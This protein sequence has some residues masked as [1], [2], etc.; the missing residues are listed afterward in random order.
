MN[1]GKNNVT[2]NINGIVV[3]QSLTMDG[4]MSLN[5]GDNDTV[6]NNKT[7]FF[8]KVHIPFE[9]TLNFGIKNSDEITHIHSEDFFNGNHPATCKISTD[10]I[11]TN[12]KG[13]YL[14]LTFGDCIPFIVYD[15]QSEYIG[16][17]HL[18]WLSICKNLH[19]KMVHYF[20]ND[21]GA[22][23]SKLTVLLGT[24]IKSPSYNF[25][26]PAQLNMP[27]WANYINQ[28]ESQNYAIDLNAYI[29]DQLVDM[30]LPKKNIHVNPID[31]GIDKD[32]FS[33]YRSAQ[34]GEKEG[35]FIF[36]AGL[37]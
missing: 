21:I 14:Y 4:N 34:F 7:A 8:N 37:L 32:F 17:G 23:I 31:T 16:L 22:D 1:I 5:Y 3:F 19:K 20:I 12:L 27:E 35:R 15:E 6:M 25:P 28:L 29:I 9:R 26:N 13:L 33:H 30:G 2:Q 36:G 18:G 24:A 11:I 10:S